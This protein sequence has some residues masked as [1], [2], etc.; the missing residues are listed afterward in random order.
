[1]EIK[2]IFRTAEGIAVLSGF[3][4]VIITGI[5]IF[6]LIGLCVYVIVNLPNGVEK[7]K[8]IFNYLKKK[9]KNLLTKQ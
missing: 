6:A 1:M 7:V 3:G 5:K 8:S 2:E 9:I 4:L